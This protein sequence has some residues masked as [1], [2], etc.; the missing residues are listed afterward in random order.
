M[1]GHVAQACTVL[2]REA[3]RSQKPSL[4]EHAVGLLRR[5][6]DAGWDAHNGGIHYLIHADLVSEGSWLL[7]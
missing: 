2:M 3:A 4:H 7:L 1:P 5:H 6:V